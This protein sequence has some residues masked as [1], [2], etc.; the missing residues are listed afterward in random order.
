MFKEK[1]KR[2]ALWMQRTGHEVLPSKNRA[3]NF[4]SLLAGA[5]RETVK[6]PKRRTTSQE[7]TE[8]FAAWLQKLA[9]FVR[10]AVSGPHLAWIRET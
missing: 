4:F 8:S 7:E 5:V 6:Q 1:K 9:A 10:R 2:H 3:R